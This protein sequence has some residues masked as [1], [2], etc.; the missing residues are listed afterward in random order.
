[1]KGVKRLEAGRDTNC[2]SCWQKLGAMGSYVRCGDCD[3]GT[4]LGCIH[5]NLKA[6]PSSYTCEECLLFRLE[7][8][9]EKPRGASRMGYWLG[10]AALLDAEAIAEGTAATYLVGQRRFLKYCEEELD[11][12]EDVV[13]PRGNKGVDSQLIRLFVSYLWQEELEPS[14]IDGYVKHLAAWN[15]SSGVGVNECSALTAAV[16]RVLKGMRRM[17]GAEG[18]GELRQAEAL[19]AE[20]VKHMLHD[21]FC[22]K[23]CRGEVLSEELAYQAAL[24][25]ILGVAGL[26]RRSELVRLRRCDIWYEE[27]TNTIVIRLRDSKTDTFRRGVEV[28][29]NG[30]AFGAPVWTLLKHQQLWLDKLGVGS[31]EKLIRSW[32]DPANKGLADNGEALSKSLR[33]MVEQVNLRNNLGLDAENYSGHSMRRGGAQLLRD[34]GVPR[35]L[36]KAAGRWRS[37]AVDV[38]FSTICR[39]SLAAVAATFANTGEEKGWRHAV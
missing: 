35:D 1:M 34:R 17:A 24:W 26:L 5:G 22:K 25:L 23:M 33:R 39:A 27:E 31:K 11:L 12:T 21:L 7:T 18:R 36:V 38:Y 29:V 32:I 13:F 14:T 6:R 3:K 2:T 16:K 9:G 37:D 19:S 15:R 4:H 20:L 8:D 30:D 28:R 10:Q